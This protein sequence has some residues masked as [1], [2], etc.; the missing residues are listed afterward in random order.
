MRPWGAFR[1]QRRVPSLSTQHARVF[2]HFSDVVFAQVRRSQINQF[3][4]RP[5]GAGTDRRPLQSWPG[6][7]QGPGQGRGQSRRSRRRPGR[8]R[9]DGEIHG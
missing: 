4:G 9:Q 6:V 3:L 1:V 2:L 8:D 7:G 5:A